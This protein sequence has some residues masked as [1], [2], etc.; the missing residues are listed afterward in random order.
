MRNP[1]AAA[2][3]RLGFAP[4][5]TSSTSGYS[6]ASHSRLLYDLVMGTMSADAALRGSLQTMRNRA[7]ELTQGNSTATAVPQLFSENVIGPDG[8]LYQAAVR[9]PGGEYDDAANAEL[10]RAWYTWCEPQFASVD[11]SASWAEL[12]SMTQEAE[13][14]DGEVLIRMITG[15]DNPFGFAIDVLDPDQLDHTYWRQPQPGQNEIRMG[16][17]VD[18]WGA[19]VAY[20]LWSN[21]PSEMKRR[22][23]VR[24]PAEEIIHL[25]IR[26]RPR[27]TRGVTWFAPMIVDLA[28]HGGYREA[29]LVAAR[30]A[31]SKQGFFELDENAEPPEGTEIENGD[32]YV[33][34]DATPG[35]F[36]QLP[37]G[38]RF[39]AWDPQH[40][41]AGFDAFDQAILRSLATGFR[42]S[43]MGISS[44][45]TKT[46]FSS[47][48][49][50]ADAER[51]VYKKLQARRITRVS[52]VVFRRWLRAAILK[53]AV[54][55]PSYDASLFEAAVWHPR[56]FSYV[57]PTKDLEFR[58]SEVRAGTNSLTR[59]AAE[60]G[61]DIVEIAYERQ[62]EIAL[63]ER[64]GVP[65]DLGSKQP[66]PAVE[67]EGSS[68]DSAEDDAE[69][70][71]DDA[72]EGETETETE[73]QTGREDARAVA[74]SSRATR[75]RLAPPFRLLRGER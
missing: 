37:K 30:I 1:F 25:Y 66:T 48:R 60:A 75:A 68:A 50:G 27:Q 7:R 24:V 38:Y 70:T 18:R 2:V 11:R 14:V 72:A 17:E 31:A 55:L 74:G 73:P 58:L 16:I 29:E 51:A 12:E 34:L 21:H 20:H 33:P 54:Q 9:R 5:A 3:E 41:N 19:P 28:M 63:F 67:A 22:E 42:V 71:K 26:R 47:G 36:E 39:K 4:R 44:D 8:I 61:R 64:L 57:D 62:R 69:D 32:P 46:S 15:F 56:T 40:P 35:S 45:L 53:G 23:R 59:L 49:L 65:L 6:G 13:V 10:E 43:Y 52:Q